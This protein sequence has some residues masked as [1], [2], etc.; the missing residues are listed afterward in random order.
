MPAVLKNAIDWL[1]RPLGSGALAGTPTAVVGTAFGQYGG[2]WAQDDARKSAGI[3]GA[4]IL[5][6]AKLAIPSSVTRFAQ[7][8]PADDS[9]AVAQL[10]Q[11]LN[12]LA[13]TIE[14]RAA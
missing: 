1:S 9:E 5:Q 4:T 8:H 12:A 6:D 7:T 10:A 13:A 14:D 2:V 3:A 11:V